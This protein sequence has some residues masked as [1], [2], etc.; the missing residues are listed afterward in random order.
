MVKQNYEGVWREPDGETVDYPGLVVHDGR[1]TGSITIG[2]TRLPVWA[3]VPSM[4]HDGA[5]RIRESYPGEYEPQD[6]ISFVYSLLDL[7]GEF[8]RLLCVLA[9]AERNE[10][11]NGW[12][13]RKTVRRRVKRALQRCVDALD[14]Q[15]AK[16]A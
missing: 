15:E 11:G 2:Y 4:M 12:W 7:R 3:V 14:A 1:V 9:K 10:H 8:A 5:A 13:K 16:Q 6:I